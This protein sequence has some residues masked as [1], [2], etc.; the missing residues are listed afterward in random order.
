MCR[1]L[2]APHIFITLSSADYH[3]PDIYRLIHKDGEVPE[4]SERERAQIMHD[5][6]FIVSHYFYER[7]Q[8]FLETVV[9]PLFGVVDHWGRYKYIYDTIARQSTLSWNGMV[10]GRSVV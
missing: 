4:L 8:T 1:Q 2:D 7:T 3:W 9:K 5:N 10:E 6:P